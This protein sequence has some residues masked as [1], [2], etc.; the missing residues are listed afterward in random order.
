MNDRSKSLAQKIMIALDYP[1]AAA[2]ETLL[3]QLEGFPCYMKVGMQ[4]FYTAGP[5]FVE[6]LKRLG[7]RVFLDLKMHDIPNTVKGGAASIARLGVD[8]FNVHDA[9]GLRMMEAAVEGA[10]S[11]SSQ[12]TCPTVIAVTQLT[13]TTEF[14]MNHELGIPGP[15]EESVLHYANIAGEAGMHGVVA[16]PLEVKRIKAQQGDAFVTVTPGIRP[17]WTSSG[18]QA[19]TMTPGEAVSEGTDYLVI[20]RAIT[21]A[22]DPVH[23]MGKIIKEMSEA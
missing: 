12:Q 5:A 10:A 4:L 23:A 15:I 16:S 14:M 2:A 9:G 1:S 3:R 17:A 21:T 11:A 13:S 19:R 6:R 20:G 7:Y 22:K 18:D 8:M